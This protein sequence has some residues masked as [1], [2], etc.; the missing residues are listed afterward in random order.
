MYMS[1]TPGHP[2]R[3]AAAVE[4]L[5]SSRDASRNNGVLVALSAE[6][7]RAF[8]LQLAPKGMLLLFMFL[9]GLH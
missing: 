3:M 2:G 6:C 5:A 8:N 7:C 4:N 9:K 1:T